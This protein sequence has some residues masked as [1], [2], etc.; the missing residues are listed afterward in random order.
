MLKLILAVWQE[1]Y[2]HSQ[3]FHVHLQVFDEFVPSTLLLWTQ[4]SISG[5]CWMNSIHVSY[6]VDFTDK[7]EKKKWKKLT[8][9]VNLGK[10]GVYILDWK[11]W[12]KKKKKAVKQ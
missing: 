7:K 6:K 3:D 12:K 4:S 1:T 9:I 5:I 10:A 8:N 11:N 2:C